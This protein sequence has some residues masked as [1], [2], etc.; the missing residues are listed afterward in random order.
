MSYDVIGE[1][2]TE[3][4][5]PDGSVCVACNYE[6][7]LTQFAIKVMINAGPLSGELMDIPHVLCGSCREVVERYKYEVCDG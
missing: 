7:Y 2:V 5:E 1:V 6:C 3:E 4:T